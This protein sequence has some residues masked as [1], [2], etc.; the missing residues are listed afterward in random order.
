MDKIDIGTAKRIAIN[1]G[2]TPGRVKGTE[3]VQFTKGDNPRLEVIGW[4]LFEEILHKR[5]LAIYQSGGW[6]KIM[7]A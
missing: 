2:L 4:P 3:G 5:G 6:M 1:K 7:N